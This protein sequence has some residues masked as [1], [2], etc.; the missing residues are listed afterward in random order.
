MQLGIE[1]EIA[2]KT[3]ADAVFCLAC[4][5]DKDNKK[6]DRAPNTAMLYLIIYTIL[7]H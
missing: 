6:H 7:L 3:C 2:W 5:K 1:V 4:S